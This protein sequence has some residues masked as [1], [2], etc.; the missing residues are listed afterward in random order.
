VVV[1][2]LCVTLAVFACGAGETA[3]PS[4]G[5]GAAAAGGRRGETT[6]GPAADAPPVDPDAPDETRAARYVALRDRV[7]AEP[8]V[9]LGSEFAAMAKELSEI[10]T[11]ARDAHLRANAALLLGSLREARGDRTAAIAE[12][13]H[14]AALVPDDAG[15]RMALA[16]ALAAAGEVSEAAEVQLQATELDPDNLENWLALGELRTRAGDQEGAAAAYV[17]YERR[18]KGLIDGLTLTDKAGA[19]L[20][21]TDERIGCAEALA[22][23]SDEGTAVALVYALTKD[24]DP[25][26]RGTVAAVMGLQRL[27]LYLPPLRQRLPEEPDT[28]VRDAIDAAIAEISAAPIELAPGAPARLPADDPRARP[29]P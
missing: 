27:S 6:P 18:R 25:A 23:A 20:I 1:G 17:D 26:V 19:P 29:Q 22:S 11:S 5:S 3:G 2:Y 4:T 8:S 14:A 28:E 24:P 10:A 12:Y 15:P 7:A 21:T 13:R 9:A 16:V